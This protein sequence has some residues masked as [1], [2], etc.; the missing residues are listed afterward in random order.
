[1]I[2]RETCWKVVRVDTIVEDQN[3]KL[4]KVKDFRFDDNTVR[5]VARDGTQGKIPWPP[6]DK[7][8]TIW[9]PST[10]DAV[11]LLKAVLGAEEV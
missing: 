3:G 6:D 7:P 11:D 1:M 2:A 4:W 10:K 5:L 8:V 9:E